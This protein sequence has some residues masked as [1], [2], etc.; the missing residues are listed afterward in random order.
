MLVFRLVSPK[1]PTDAVDVDTYVDSGAAQSLFDGELANAIN[2]S[3][4]D[5][6]RRTFTSTN[7][8]EVEAYIHNVTLVHDELGVFAMEVAFSTSGIARNLLGRDFFAL[9][10]IGFRERHSELYVTP[11]P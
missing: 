4:L 6:R 2:L 10:Q 3:L 5:G 11:A 7:R 9:T 1:N 8:A